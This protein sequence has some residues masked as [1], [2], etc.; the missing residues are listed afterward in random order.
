MAT[1][2]WRISEECLRIIYGGNIPVAGKVDIEELKISVCQVTNGLLKT[3]YFQ[4]NGKTGESIP[5]GTSLGLYEGILV[6]KWKNV[7]QCTLPVKPIKLPR[8]MGIYSL[9]DPNNPSFEFIPVQMGQWGLLQSQP[10]IN[11][12]LGQCGYENFGMQIVFSKDI[13]S[14]DPSNP[15]T[16]SMRLAIMDI[17]Q[18]G[19]F[20]P[21]PILPEMEFMVKQQV[22]ALYGAEITSDKLVDAGHKEQKGV[23]INQQT[24]S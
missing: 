10:L 18:Y 14:D 3:E 12:L 19:D 6:S 1:T 15:T 4:I 9:F 7:S 24:Q 2:I 20:D 22:C 13:S 16:V 21:L 23:P 17:A 5:N 11:D 8:N